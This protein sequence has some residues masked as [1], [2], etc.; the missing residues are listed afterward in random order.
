MSARD[1]WIRIATFVGVTYAWSWIFMYMAIAAGEITL[2]P[3][4]GG[5]WSPFVGIL[6]TR[7]IFPDGRRRGSLSGL[8]WK[9]G[10]TR[11]RYG[12]SRWFRKWRCHG[13]HG[14]LV[15]GTAGYCGRPGGHSARYCGIAYPN[16][17]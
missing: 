10:K 16:D 9:W 17:V 14:A 13:E 7:L 12:T 3:A 1:T 2:L 11:W 8:G 4:F 6:V 15:Q 5:M